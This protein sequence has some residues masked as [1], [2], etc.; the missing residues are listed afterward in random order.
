MV[1]LKKTEAKGD[2]LFKAALI[3][4][5]CYFLY[6]SAVLMNLYNTFHEYSDYAVFL[7]NLYMNVNYPQITHGLQSIAFDTHLSPDGLFLA[8]MYYFFQSPLTLLIVQLGFMCITAFIILYAVRD[9]TGSSFWAFAFCFAFLINPGTVGQIVYDSH[10]E[11]LM[12]PFYILTL[13]FYMKGEFRLFA[14]SSVLLLGSADIASA[15]ALTLGIGLVLYELLYNKRHQ[16]TKTNINFAYSLVLM[17]IIAIALYAVATHS[18]H[19]SYSTSYSSLPPAIGI[20]GA[21]NQVGPALS[22]LLHNP[23]QTI[24]NDFNLYAGPYKIYLV[25]A[26]LLII[27]GF[28]LML[29]ADPLIALVFG[30]SWLG[31]VFIIGNPSFLLPLSEYFGVIVCPAVSAAIIG[32]IISKRKETYLSNA[33]KGLGL[34]FDRTVKIAAIVLPV[35]FSIVGPA[36][37][38]FAYS[39]QTQYHSFS[40]SDI[41]QIVFLESNASQKTAYAQLNS[42]IAQIPTNASVMTQYYDIAHVSERRYVEPVST[43]Y[44]QPEYILVDFNNNISSNMC[45]FDNCTRLSGLVNS[46]NYSIYFRNGTAILYGLNT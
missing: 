25:Y 6:F 42:A 3:L 9:L 43:D 45:L 4:I 10:I 32:L 41:N 35:L 16:I 34:D 27:F 31:G 21:Q 8:L 11:F 7:Y 14:L 18:L 36:A 20:Y 33:I 15:M 12:Q 38:L 40:A 37:Y 1:N 30:L 22:G 46:D 17:S 2:F 5:L 28:G 44:F 23:G 13:Y 29:L 24:A 26:M 39:P 19:S